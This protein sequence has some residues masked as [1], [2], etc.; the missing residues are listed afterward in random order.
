[1]VCVVKIPEDGIVISLQKDGNKYFRTDQLIL[2]DELYRF[3]NDDDVRKLIKINPNLKD[4]L[5]DTCFIK[6][7]R[8]IID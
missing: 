8:H 3:D 4:Y 2:T 7:N 1:M 6:Q 5:N